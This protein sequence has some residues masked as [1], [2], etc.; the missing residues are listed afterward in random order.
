MPVSS[1]QLELLSQQLNQA[2][3]NAVNAELA[4]R[5]LG[6]VGHPMLLTILKSS[7]SENSEGQCGAQRDLAELLNISPA[8]V[9]NSLK[10]LERSGYTY[11]EPQRKDARRNRM[12]LTDKGRQAVEGCQEVF[13][14]V[15]KRM[16]AGFTPEEREQ[17]YSFRRRMLNNL[18]GA[19]PAHTQA[20][21]EA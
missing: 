20:K 16:M 9:A 19:G 1:S 12:V 8:A 5:G 21:E 4:A 14:A 6:E 7:G 15:S 3:R 18:R 17:L 11:R 2:H 13:A 10:S